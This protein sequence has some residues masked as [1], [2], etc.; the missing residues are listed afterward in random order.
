[1]A[2]EN[3][4]RRTWKSMLAWCLL[5]VVI[6]MPTRVLSADHATPGTTSGTAATN[7]K[8]PSRQSGST[9]AKP[10]G[11]TAPTRLRIDVPCRAWVPPKVLPKVVLLCVHGLGLNSASYEDFGQRMSKL[12]IA[13]Y[14]V[15]VRGFGT[16]M[17]LEGKEQI[18]F[19]ACIEDVAQALKVL[20]TAYPRLPIFVLGESMG[21]AIALRVTA[22]H[23]ELVDGLIS[24]VPSGDRFHKTKSELLVAL[25]MVTGAGKKPMDVGSR[26]IEEATDDPS[27]REEWKGDPL[28]RLKIT[29]KELIQFQKFMNENH[30]TAKQI[31]NRPVLFL[32]GFK[33]KL[34]KPQ[35]TIEL[36]NEV[37]TADKMLV[38][39]G[40]GE[41]LIFEQNQL[42]D[43]VCWVLMGWLKSHM[44]HPHH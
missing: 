20:H 44:E 18:D 21:G 11:K 26:T 13:T 31:V 16:W 10:S 38:V 36:F 22:L 14:A 23:P 40:D 29:P 5:L 39:V 41:H 33:D 32:A 4:A 27:V 25:R 6:G 17:K 1:M 9:K 3:L 37:T 43:Q 24:A 30:E 15:D 42:T 34:V 7:G 35:G 28:N 12:G 2:S 8:S 19:N